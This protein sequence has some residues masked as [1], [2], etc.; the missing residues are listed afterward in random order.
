MKKKFLTKVVLGLGALSM[1]LSGCGTSSE[2]YS[3]DERYEI[4]KYAVEDGYT[5]TY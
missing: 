5:G 2:D 4:Y 3:G 1:A